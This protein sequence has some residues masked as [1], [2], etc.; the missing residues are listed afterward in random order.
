[1]EGYS[2]NDLM[3]FDSG[4]HVCF[5]SNT[6]NRYIKVSDG[7]RTKAMAETER[8]ILNSKS[9]FIKLNE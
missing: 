1:M 9:V 5:F 8:K 7:F 3:Q 4:W 6:Q 2:K